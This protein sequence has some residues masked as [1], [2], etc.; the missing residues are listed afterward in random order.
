MLLDCDS[1][2]QTLGNHCVLCELLKLKTL[3][4]HL[5]PNKV[6][7]QIMQ[8]SHFFQRFYHVFIFKVI[9]LN[10]FEIVLVE[11]PSSVL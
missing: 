10:I 5:P 2:S 1:L 11:M 6:E 3:V 7:S 9:C 8:A 4:E